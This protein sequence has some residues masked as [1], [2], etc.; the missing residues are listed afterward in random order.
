MQSARVVSDKQRVVSFSPHP[1]FNTQPCDYD[2]QPNPPPR[3]YH[4]EPYISG[5]TSR[6]SPQVPHAP[7][8]ELSPDILAAIAQALRQGAPATT[9]A[10]AVQSSSRKYFSHAITN[11]TSELPMSVIKELRAGFKNYIPLTLCTHK[12]CRYAT[13]ST[14]PIDTEI[15]WT[16]K[17]EM[18][19]KQRSMNAAK[20]YNLSTND[21]TRLGRISFVVFANTWSWVMILVQGESEP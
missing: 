20:D 21:F 5:Q 3:E 14:D 11:A 6:L 18:R 16:E 12:A 13:R 8:F 17:G 7:Q 4:T 15:G 1:Y 10:Q 9:F 2:P 19:L